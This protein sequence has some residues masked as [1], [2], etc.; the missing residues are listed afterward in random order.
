MSKTFYSHVSADR[1]VQSSNYTGLELHNFPGQFFDVDSDD[2]TFTKV[3][4]ITR[5]DF[6][7]QESTGALVA[8]SMLHGIGGA[9]GEPRK[10]GFCSHHVLVISESGF[11]EM[12]ISSG[13]IFNFLLTASE[14]NWTFITGDLGGDFYTAGFPVSVSSRPVVLSLYISSN[15]SEPLLGYLNGNLMAMVESGNRANY[16]VTTGYFTTLAYFFGPSEEEYPTSLEFYESAI[17]LNPES[18][19]IFARDHLYLVKKYRELL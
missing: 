5:M 12:N 6:V 15:P 18:T 13:S 9:G 7:G 4:G 19:E 10:K 1:Y 11:V 16:R 17:G 3:N 14:D 8:P 2:S